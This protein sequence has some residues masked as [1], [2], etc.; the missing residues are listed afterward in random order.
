MRKICINCK[1]EKVASNNRRISEFR[2]QKLSSDGFN[3]WCKKCVRELPSSMQICT[4][5]HISKPLEDFFFDGEKSGKTNSRHCWCRSCHSIKD[6]KERTTDKYINGF[7]PWRNGIWAENR[8]YVENKKKSGCI[9]CTE[10][11]V[12]ALDF[13]HIDG[14]E[15]K[16]TVGKLT[17]C[18]SKN[19][20]KRI[21]DEIGKCVILCANCHR[22]LHAGR[23]TLT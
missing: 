19:R 20:R 16:D 2:K 3:P 13:H 4:S 17:F 23:F 1:S 10:K 5:C 8:D 15:K 9:R 14:N 6:K 12:K 21:D 18:I 7:I 22:K 11:D